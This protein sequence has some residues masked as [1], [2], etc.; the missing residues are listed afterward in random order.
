MF[1]IDFYRYYLSAYVV[2][3]ILCNYTSL[4]PPTEHQ[5]AMRPASPSPSASG[6][7]GS[8]TISLAKQRVNFWDFDA[9]SRSFLHEKKLIER[10]VSHAECY[11]T[12]YVT[13]TLCRRK[14]GKEKSR[15]EGQ[16]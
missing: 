5:I 11:N 13:I 4:F 7:I 14:S 15:K 8:T 10:E 1:L 6:S 12:M 16:F 9:Y 3:F 2:L